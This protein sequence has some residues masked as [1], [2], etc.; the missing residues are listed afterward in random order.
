MTTPAA[1]PAVVKVMDLLIHDIDF[2]EAVVRARRALELGETLL[3][4]TP[5]VDHAVRGRRDEQ[6]RAAVNATDLRLADGAWIRR[7]ARIAGLPLRSSVTGR[8]LVP[9]LCAHA[10]AASIPVGL[11]GGP[12]GIAERAAGRLQARF[13]GLQVVL[14]AAPPMGF[15]VGSPEDRALTDVVARSDAKL[16]FVGLG[17]PRQELWMTANR[18]ALE[19]RVIA[20]IGAGL[21]IVAGRFRAA[22][23]WMTR[24]GLEWLYRLAQEPR[25]LARRYL[26]DDP[27]IFAWAFRER[28]RRGGQLTH[29]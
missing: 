13:P 27:A 1:E 25:R 28:A 8:L 18:A 29:Q 19:G 11:V 5:N 20:G 23:P 16:V 6:F 12:P 9:V 2:T 7:A 3:I 4:S 21:D 24:L 10:A 22:P 15:V 17:A 26:V 14:T